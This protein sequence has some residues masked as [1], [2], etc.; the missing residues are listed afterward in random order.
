MAKTKTIFYCTECGYETSTYLG[1]CSSCGAWDSL[2]EARFDKVKSKSKLDKDTGLFL[3]AESE[4]LTLDQIKED[5]ISRLDTLSPE[6][7]RV[8]GGGIVPG[9]LTLLGG[10]PGVGKSTLLLQVAL[11]FAKQNQQVLYISAEES[12][13]Q[14]KI[15]ATRLGLAMKSPIAALHSSSQSSLTE[16]QLRYA[17]TRK[18]CSERFDDKTVSDIQEKILV[19][20]ESDIRA[21]IDVIE[22][23][24]PQLVIVDSI[25]ALY[26]PDIDSVP[27]APSQIKDSATKLMRT[28]KSTN[29]PI[30]IVGHINKDGDLAGPKI[31]EHMVD[32][33]LQFESKQDSS[34]RFIRSIKNRFGN[35]NEIAVYEMQQ[36]GLKDLLNPSQVFLEQKSGGV[37]F[38]SKEGRRSL[39]LEIQALALNTNY[40]N[41]R[42][43]ANGV[44]LG[45]V[46]Q[47]LAILEKQSKLSFASV[48][49]YVNVVGG[50]DLGETASDLAVALAIY[51][52]ALNYTQNLDIV[53]IGEIGLSGEI[54]SVTD[55]EARINEAVKLGFKKI[56]LPA[57]NLKNLNKKFEGIELVGIDKLIEAIDRVF[58]KK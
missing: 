24:E 20:P 2:K 35:T 49:V 18:P 17:Q 54:R 25:Q 56:L 28:A 11:N 40:H 52:S 57:K 3:R 23:K 51:K 50:I 47:I 32:T 58:G 21:I 15:R 9:S 53:A 14:L 44:D 39:L 4:L 48:D 34:L 29:I 33:V 10:Q 31:L 46:H 22:S 1:R 8:L 7:N 55:I 38:A 16:S 42:R 5:E 41:P 26:N 36:E 43:L 12:S 45:R 37:I 13:K 19:Y 6:F 27:G 30:I